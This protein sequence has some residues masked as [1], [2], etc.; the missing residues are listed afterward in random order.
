MVP[1][2]AV[3][4]L[5]Q[6]NLDIACTAIEKA[7]MER[8]VS[9]VD[10]GFAASYDVRRRHR[11]VSPVHKC[12]QD[13]SSEMLSRRFVTVRLSGILLL[14]TRVSRLR[15]PNPCKSKQMGY[16]NTKR[17]FT[18][19]LVSCPPFTSRYT[20]VQALLAMDSKRRPTSRPSSTMSFTAPIYPQSPTPDQ[21]VSNQSFLSHQDAMDRFGVYFF[22][23]CHLMLWLIVI[24]RLC[25]GIWKPSWFNCLFNRLRLYLLTTIFVTWFDKSCS[26]PRNPLTA[27]VRR[28]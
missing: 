11:E 13:S 8:A 1:E 28:F 10:E 21:P 12:T 2:Q 5:V 4:L 26:W 18:K 3:L 17:A 7:A 9:D 25:P 14:L 19:I 27:I 20:H 22:L 23:Y 15:F 16:S 6:D 24:L